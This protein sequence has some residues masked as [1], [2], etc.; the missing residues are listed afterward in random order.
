MKGVGSEHENDQTD[1]EHRKRGRYVLKRTNWGK[2]PIVY[3]LT[4]IYMVGVV[5]KTAIE[6]IPR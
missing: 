5:T 4:K 6:P 1:K 2:L 3:C